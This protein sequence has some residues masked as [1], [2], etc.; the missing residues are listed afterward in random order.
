MSEAQAMTDT[1][2]AT[3]LFADI[4]DSS[5]LSYVLAPTLYQELV[6]AF[7][8]VADEVVA[9]MLRKTDRP[10]KPVEKSIH[11]DELYLLLGTD[12]STEKE[13]KSD[14]AR[15]RFAW[16]A[17]QIAIRL[18]RRWVLIDQ[19]SQRIDNGQP[20]ISIGIGIHAGPVVLCDPAAGSAG[21]TEPQREKTAEGYPINIA[22][23]V[24][25][26][27]RS[28]R[29]SR[30]YLTRPIYNRT[31]AD[32]RQ[33]FVR[34]DVAELK[35]V[36]M[37]PI[38][39][40]AKGVGHFD[41]KAFPKSP[42]FENPENLRVYEKI[43]TT[44]PDEVWLL[45]DLAHKYF[46]DGDYRQAQKK[47]KS[48]I[49]VD[50]DFAPAYAY[51]GRAYFRDYHLP[52]AREALE[53]ATELDRGQAR[54]NH[55]LAVCLRRQAMFRYYDGQQENAR[56]LL[57]EALEYHDKACRISSLE[58]MD[59]PWARNGLNWTIAQCDE[60]GLDSV[61]YGLEE[62]FTRSEE[63]AK[64]VKDSTHWQPKRHLI[65]HTM[66]F[67]RLQ[68]GRY[69]EAHTYLTEAM[70]ALEDRMADP[71]ARPD[72]KGYAERKAELLYHIG[73]CLYQNEEEGSL[74]K[75][76]GFW[77]KAREA[78]YKAWGRGSEAA[79]AW[80][81]QYWIHR[82]IHVSKGTKMTIKALVD[83]RLGEE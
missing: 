22:K 50:V 57:K 83:R 61:P 64:K 37:A 10:P 15:R 78:I 43:V 17:L 25:T 29:F 5:M 32:F 40:E 4:V 47:Y 74:E 11:G 68:Q 55:Y 30:I 38:I 48:V 80:D 77:V 56:E 9:D 59:F 3:I 24:E 81:G 46:D 63:L 72:G 44:N 60:V 20:P 18:K 45:L 8:R 49:E 39:Y 71:E 52:E 33:A 34:V 13:G 69:R 42:E 19:N 28:G 2:D 21:S 65:L 6:T 58:N 66:G 23:R 70:S 62:A 16:L 79:T 41:D 14:D 27:S 54:A 7:Q 67:I 35:G 51:L 31:P 26:A 75:A 12:P 1:I 73:L 36:P 76:V 53:R 82:T